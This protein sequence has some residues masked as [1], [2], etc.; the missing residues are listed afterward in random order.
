MYNL[1]FVSLLLN[2]FY[3]VFIVVL[4]PSVCPITADIL[5]KRLYESSIFFH[6]PVGPSLYFFYHKRRFKIGRITPSMWALN[7]VE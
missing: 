5:S 6:H 2:A 7:S 1:R 4:C 3:V